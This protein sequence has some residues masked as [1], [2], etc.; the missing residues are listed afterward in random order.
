MV[1]TTAGI[2]SNCS[3]LMQ[4]LFIPQ[5]LLLLIR[6][7]ASLAAFKQLFCCCSV[8][9]RST[10]ISKISNQQATSLLVFNLLL[11]LLGSY[12]KFKFEVSW[13][14]TNN[15]IWFPGFAKLKKMQNLKCWS[16]LNLMQSF[17]LQS[18]YYTTIL[19][20]KTAL[21]SKYSNLCC[22]NKLCEVI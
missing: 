22:K 1:C 2:Q 7:I 6:L 10:V 14:Y 15:I 13:K 17:A 12:L 20:T 11:W 19:E 18:R 16:Q 5:Q 9:N 8:S 4:L 21:T 3:A